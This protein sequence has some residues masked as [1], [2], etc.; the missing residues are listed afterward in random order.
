MGDL[1]AKE[2]P[3]PRWHSSWCCRC[4]RSLAR[5]SVIHTRQT[6]PD[7]DNFWQSLIPTETETGLYPLCCDLRVRKTTCLDVKLIACHNTLI[8]FSE[9]RLCISKKVHVNLKCILTEGVINIA[10]GS[11]KYMWVSE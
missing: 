8:L 3:L 9:L 2:G 4:T 7:F 10:H 6:Y 5:N 11:H 1:R